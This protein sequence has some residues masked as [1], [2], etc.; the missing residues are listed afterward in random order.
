MIYLR[1]WI[2]GKKSKYSI[3]G[4]G[5]IKS[6]AKMTKARSVCDH[7]FFNCLNL[8]EPVEEQI[9]RMRGGRYNDI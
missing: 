8:D 5:I 7:P 4:K 3:A 1:R 9:N 6:A 2:V